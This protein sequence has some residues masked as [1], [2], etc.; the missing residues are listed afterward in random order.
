[1]T[2]AIS[3]GFFMAMTKKKSKKPDS[4]ILELTDQYDRSA[5]DA[6]PLIDTYE[7]KEDLLIG[8]LEDSVSRS[9]KS[10]VFVPELANIIIERSAR[11]MAQNA[12]GKVEAITKKN[13]GK[14]KMMDLTLHKYIIPNANQFRPHLVKNRMWDVYS[15]VYG[16][17]P[18]LVDYFVTDDY[19]GPDYTFI[20]LRD[21]VWQVGKNSVD[22]CDYLFV[23][24]VVSKKWLLDR[25]TK[26]WKNIDK[27][28]E[29]VKT[30]PGRNLDNQTSTQELYSSQ[31]YVN[32]VGDGYEQ[33]E[34]ITRYEKDRWVTFSND[35]EIVVRDIKNP[36]KNNKIP[37]VMKDAFPLMDRMIGLGEFERGMTLN[38]AVNGLVNLY[39]DGVK[40]SIFPPMKLYL[41]DLVAKTIKN[42]AGA[43][44][45]LK[46][47]NPN[48]VTEHIRNPQ[49]LQ[50]FQSTYSFMKSAILNIG[51]S[52][53]TQSSQETDPG[54][55]KTPQA[56]KM[57]A[58]RE[59]ARD[60]W[61]R[62]MM[63]QALEQV[64]NRFIDLVANKQ[65][66]PLKL[67]LMKE[68]L[69]QIA[70]INPD[71][72]EMFE[73]GE[74]GQLIVKP[75][76]VK[77]TPYKFSIDSGSTL[78]KD[79]AVENETITSIIALIMKMPNAMSS[80]ATNGTVQLGN[81]VIDF[82]ELFKRF[83]ITASL[84]DWE[85]IVRDLSPEEQQQLKMM[86]QSQ[87]QAQPNAQQTS[88]DPSQQAQMGMQMPPQG[89]NQ[90]QPVN[91]ETQQAQQMFGGMG[92]S[93]TQGQPQLSQS[94]M[95]V[96]NELMNRGK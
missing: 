56:L 80:I 76:D 96:L 42:E 61:D 72:V 24:S 17:Y 16:S 89:Q 58:M 15:N 95:N 11:V 21:L 54:M 79:D 46:N 33:I 14:S 65:E 57:Q 20:P 8:E 48:A 40:M 27:L 37:V 55:G 94:S 49:G 82:G 19:V 4:L 73:S 9:A 86:A 53:T 34:L 45:L 25:N 85:K 3:S 44:W 31:D 91:F 12:T 43:K 50:T 68:E 6:Q 10:K 32:D 41:P 60:N 64:Y 18:V 29:Y 30:K 67:Y 83:V 74:S 78:K 1:M 71:V 51:G 2:G 69:E 77:D 66:K 81:K 62:F 28:L 22:E 93:N 90:Q 13:V 70:K 5:S 26:D 23:R 35:A 38:Y 47:M 52:S 59:A 92:Q 84:Q 39:M 7:E 75:S 63:E 87:A 88:I 36:Q